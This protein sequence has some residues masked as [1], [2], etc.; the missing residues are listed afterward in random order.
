MFLRI[1][2]DLKPGTKSR[3]CVCVC[4]CVSSKVRR[5]AMKDSAQGSE[6]LLSEHKHLGSVPRTGNTHTH[7]HTH[8]RARA[9]SYQ[10]L[11]S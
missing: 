5:E 3:P 2:I 4:V 11:H 1:N 7:T 8:T 6:V 9:H 10:M